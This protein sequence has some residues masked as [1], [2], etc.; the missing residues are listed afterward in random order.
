MPDALENAQPA[1]DPADSPNG[2]EGSG[3][4]LL[5][6]GSTNQ[7]ANVSRKE[8]AVHERQSSCTNA[9]S[10]LKAQEAHAA[11]KTRNGGKQ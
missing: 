7:V 4:M 3:G 10:Y 5:R 2:S 6:A 11:G 8:S 9:S 1:N